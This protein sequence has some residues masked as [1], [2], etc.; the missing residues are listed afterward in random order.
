MIVHGLRN[1]ATGRRVIVLLLLVVAMIVA[2]NLYFTPAYQAVSGG[3]V[4]FDMQFPLGAE[5]IGIQLALLTPESL[6]VYKQYLAIDF[7]FPIVGALFTTLLWSWVLNRIQMHSLNRFYAHGLW[8]LPFVPAGF[9]LAENVLFL[10]I[11]ANAPDAL[12]ETIDAAVAVHRYK[13]S[14]LSTTMLITAVLVGTAALTWL[15]RRLTRP[16]NRAMP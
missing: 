11:V 3:T 5:A 14:F 9:D 16:S 10:R 12:P 1:H 13:M 6:A 4:P 8:L 7:M 15:L 2:L